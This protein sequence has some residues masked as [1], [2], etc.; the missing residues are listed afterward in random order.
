[1]DDL[2]EDNLL[3]ICEEAVANSI[4]HARPRQVKVTLACCSKHIQLLIRDDGCGFDI[5]EAPKEGH[6]GLLGIM[7]RVEALSGMLSIDSTPGRGTSLLV[8]VPPYRAQRITFG[9]HRQ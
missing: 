4:K 1:M 2:I 3:R 7:E 6:F 5:A 8:A 9:E